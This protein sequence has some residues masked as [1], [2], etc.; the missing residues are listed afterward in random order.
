MYGSGEPLRTVLPATPAQREVWLA[1]QMDPDSD[2]YVIAEYHEIRGPIDPAALERAVRHTVAEAE[3]LSSAFHWVDD[4]LWFDIRPTPDWPFP[5]LDLTSEPDPLRAARIWMDRELRGWS[6]DGS[7]FR[8]ALLKVGVDHWILFSANHHL[9]N[10]GFGASLV[11]RRFAQ[12]YTAEVNR[13]DA[14]PLT[15]RTVA[16]VAAHLR[17]HASETAA[18]DRAWWTALFADR[19]VAPRL[20]TGRHPG[21]SGTVRRQ[22]T[23]L[24]DTLSQRLRESAQRNELR[25]ST[26]FLSA[27]AVYTHRMTGADDVI[28]GVPV[29]RRISPELR[30]TPTMLSGGVP[31]RVSVTATATL[32]E[33]HSAVSEF[34]RLALRH[35]T[36]GVEDLMR[37]L[38]LRVGDRSL[39]GPRLNFMSFDYDHTFDGAQAL[40]HNLAAAGPADNLTVNVY[41]RSRQSSVRLD[42]DGPAGL[43]SDAD[44]AAHR[45]RLVMLVAAFADDLDQRVDAVDLVTDS[46]R[47]QLRAS[48]GAHIPDPTVAAHSSA[49]QS[50]A[51][52]VVRAA[53]A[54][55]DRVALVG[56]AETLTYAQLAHHTRLV[57]DRLRSDH[58]VGPGDR[59]AVI[60]PRG[61]D[62]IVAVTAIVTLGAAYVPIDPSYPA[63]RIAFT[64]HDARPSVAITDGS[65]DASQVIPADRT[66]ALTAAIRGDWSSASSAASTVERR[67]TVVH[68]DQP[69]YVIY[70]SGTTGRPKG[71]VVSHRAVLWLLAASRPHFGSDADDIWLMATSMAFDIA[72]WQLWDAVS[73][74]STMVLAPIGRDRHRRLAAM[75]RTH[76]VTVV[77]H[78]PSGYRQLA[79][80]H[81]NGLESVKRVVLGG[82]A[83]DVSEVVAAT[84]AVEPAIVNVYGVTEATVSSTF[85]VVNPVDGCQV[86]PI[87]AP[88]PGARVYV[89][90]DR[91]RLLAPGGVG[92]LYVGGSGVA[93]GYWGRPGLTAG[94]FVSDPFGDAGDRLYRTGDLVRWGADGQLDYVGRRDQQV[95]VRGHRVELGEIESVLTGHT[96][97]ENAVATVRSHGIDDHRIT[98][99][100]VPAMVE[101]SD[102]P[103]H[104]RRWRQLYDAMYDAPADHWTEFSGWNSVYTGEPIP[105]AE[106]REWRDEAVT[107]VVRFRPKRVLEIG[108][109]SGLLLF[110][111]VDHVDEYWATDLS[112]PALDRIID[113]AAGSPAA[114]RITVRLR[115][116]DD[117]E[118]LPRRHFD[119]IVLNSVVQ[120]FPNAGHLERVLD[121]LLELLAPGGRIIVGD[122]RDLRTYRRLRTAVETI[123]TPSA[124][125]AAIDSAI[126]S[127]WLLEPEL[128]VAPDWFAGWAEGVEAITGVDIRLKAGRAHNE[129]TRHRYE[130]VLHTA[131][132]PR[133]VAT[134]PIA[135]WGT[136]VA[137]L[138]E[139][140]SRAGTTGLRVCSIP[141]ARLLDEPG[142]PERPQIEALEPGEVLAAAAAADRTALVT[143]D[144]RTD[145]RFNL[146]VVPSSDNGDTEMYTD[147]YLRSPHR[148][149]AAGNPSRAH[150]LR[151]LTAELR[152]HLAARLPDHMVPSTIIPI[153]AVP[154]TPNGKIDHVALPSPT[155]SRTAGG[156][157]PD[158][159]HEQIIV[160]LFADVLN[161]PAVGPDDD[162]FAL[163]GHS[164]LATTLIGRLRAATGAEVSVRDVFD[165]PTPASL[166]AVLIVGDSRR[167]EPRQSDRSVNPPL[168]SAQ[169]R[170][171]FLDQLQG[172]A[173][174]YNIPI[175]VRIGDPS[176]SDSAAGGVVDVDATA[177]RAA[178][179]DVI[180]R[181]DTLRTVFPASDGIPAARVK[182]SETIEPEWSEVTGDPDTVSKFLTTAAGT[183]FDLANDLP[184]RAVLARPTGGNPA[185]LIVIHHI[186][187]DGWSVRPLLDDLRAAYR[188]RLRDDDP[189]LRP[190]PLRYSDFAIWQSEVLGDETDPTSTV[191]RATAYWCRQLAGLPTCVSVPAARTRP[192]IA[193]YRG[194]HLERILDVGLHRGI[195]ALARTTGTTLFMVAH[196]ALAALLTRSG[197]GTDV[198]I[199]T[200][201]AGR[202]DPLWE[203]VIGCFVNTLVLRLDTS[204]NPTFADLLRRSREVS[205]AAHAH[206]DVP[207]E[208]LIEALNP[209]RS[210]SHQPFFQISLVVQNAP[211]PVR[212]ADAGGPIFRPELLGTQSSR[213]DLTVM[214]TERTSASGAAAGIDVVAEYATDLLDEV[215]VALLLDQWTS[216]LRACVV[217]PTRPIGD[218]PLLTDRDVT[219]LTTGD[220][221][222]ATPGGPPPRRGVTI[223]SSLADAFHAQA[224]LSPSEPAV[225]TSEGTLA[226]S[227][228]AARTARLARHLTAE[229]GVLPG[230]RVAL[231]LPRGVDMIVA[232][233]AVVDSGAAYVPIDPAYPLTR[234]A[235]TLADAAPAVVVTTTDLELPPSPGARVLRLT[236]GARTSIAEHAPRRPDVTVL[237]DQPAY[238]IYTSGTTG[239]PKGAVIAHRGALELADDQI[240]RWDIGAGDRI[241][242][243]SSP[244]F[245]ASLWEW[246]CALTSGAALVVPP[247]APLVGDTLVGAIDDFDVTLALIPPSVLA[248]TSS[249]TP[250]TL[251]VLLI[252]GEV[253]PPH[254]VGHWS[255]PVVANGYGPTETTVL[256]CAEMVE[257]PVRQAVP[258]G[259]PLTGVRL[260]VLDDR[261]RLLAPGA[262][263][264]LYV[265]G[266]GVAVGYWDRPGLT[267]GRFIA[268]PFGR[269]GD[270][271]YRTG[272]LVRWGPGWE[273][274]YVGRRDQ[275]V[276]VRGHRVELGEIESVLVGHDAVGHAAAIARSDGVDDHRIVAYVVPTPEIDADSDDATRLGAEL[277]AAVGRTL[278]DFM[279]PTAVVPVARLPLTPNGKLDVEALE[280][281]E[282]TVDGPVPESVG[283][284]PRT[285][286]EEVLCE[287]FAEVLERDQVRIDQNFFELGGHSLLAPRLATRVNDVF[288]VTISVR[289]VFSAPTP[290]ELVAALD[291]GGRTE[292]LDVLLP[293][294]TG[295][296]HPPLFCI[297]PAGGFG[298]PY[299]GLLRHVDTDVP[300]YA[301]QARGLLPG[302]TP[303]SSIDEMADDYAAQILSV[304]PDGP[305]VLLG[306]SFGGVVAHA[307]AAR[308][309]A[310]GHVVPLLIML[311]AV[312]A[313][314]LTDTEYAHRLEEMQSNMGTL[315][316]PTVVQLALEVFNVDTTGVDF[317]DMTFEG[318]LEILDEKNSALAGSDE[319]LLTAIMTT[320][321]NNLTI[322][323]RY[324]HDVVDTDVL[325]F[326]AGLEADA[327]SADPWSR[328]VTGAVA[329]HTAPATHVSFMRPEVLRE[330]GPVISERIRGVAAL[331]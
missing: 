80:E 135:T 297:H 149:P 177:L 147:T 237:P 59:V 251:R 89:L 326:T 227:E 53:S 240:R 96:S 314:D 331:I 153:A 203:G 126:G 146:V 210:T 290:A 321:Y 73:S 85:H 30:E 285:P 231:V 133:S 87:G 75:I 288:G 170:L 215:T 32:R 142:A 253:C 180:G 311:D 329:S 309:T 112:A 77:N 108:A 62:A 221:R 254:L 144:A 199:G 165:A 194:A 2:A 289:E 317:T 23:D 277:R 61:V 5:I 24:G 248:S 312:P 20:Q 128:V 158:G 148:R 320:V 79:A 161:N 67:G 279:V 154:L 226:Y 46:E 33:I 39:I 243:F 196:A 217:N 113:T 93:L 132:S 21:G 220:P 11:A 7:L 94:R 183:S 242:C 322:S 137:S 191:S 68:P 34:L 166:A 300:I 209:V 274:E 249:R 241:L 48:G 236:S 176:G 121:G 95:K 197:A 84:P 145:D 316:M 299:T 298:W 81:P 42:V 264:E 223:G 110:G 19:P 106:M 86:A 219:A 56:E 109:G 284:P 275:Q 117:T 181:H 169:R 282:P 225:I 258:L 114:D 151:E 52:L 186:A 118:G 37:D 107:Q 88:L 45:D 90:D 136:D 25:L 271:L 38:G 105:L 10:D 29:T 278:P 119:T 28:L 205:L 303:A 70:T 313:E 101:A 115:S 173:P 291:A 255:V 293:L 208:H 269:D 97:V 64:V 238:L 190:L 27:L 51:D 55:P 234:I 272:D 256:V 152:S 212:A 103:A 207:F 164:L 280:R 36:Y 260:Y 40:V 168:S 120:Y 150:R 179:I 201:T 230:D 159:P 267:S 222:Q 167:P 130:V 102:D 22:S 229:C 287:L 92:E 83:L 63:D 127:S 104:V 49:P 187:A 58:G 213:F 129:L 295:G 188:A 192:A 175:L 270:R 259:G 323:V 141:N 138:D 198:P 12:R 140:W 111:I 261:L 65:A 57:A 200:V 160:D 156:R 66:M 8:Y 250:T 315:D 245:D 69:A 233:L 206:Q 239:A 162:F 13:V 31:L 319:Q 292:A 307:V 131:A 185:L 276:K 74:G 143:P 78:T 302:T 330:I 232:I 283:L 202:L 182:D 99:Y 3:A 262:V 281:L 266:S 125:P 214:L 50:L 246:L 325:A 163:G 14:L 305:Y 134:L 184:I 98:A 204:G 157:A 265:G 18:T 4:E 122:V 6:L 324:R 44:L 72:V 273:L 244:S 310:R 193:S 263:G 189:G 257:Q 43:Y 308:L 16:D 116:A 224:C 1:L 60:L 139:I 228:L 301:L 235:V 306:W 9:V 71:V 296:T 304:R 172:Q 174:V 247:V 252:A 211:G 54:D 195:D 47:A 268:D 26:I 15:W 328:V 216:L 286:Q 327:E 123:A 76:P 82:E 100:I 318:A 178:L 294:R 17:D 124:S 171:W 91:L 155:V 41:E 35:Q 218:Y